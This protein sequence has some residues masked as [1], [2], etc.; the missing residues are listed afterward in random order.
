MA[1]E[2]RRP[3]PQHS[4]APVPV[5]WPAALDPVLAGA[6]I[7]LPRS[8]DSG[9]GVGL[10]TLLGSLFAF[11]HYLQSSD[12]SDNGQRKSGRAVGSNTD[13]FTTS[14]GVSRRRHTG[15]FGDLYD[16]SSL[17]APIGRHGHRPRCCWR[18]SSTMAWATWMSLAASARRWSIALRACCMLASCSAALL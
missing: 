17:P 1:R 8:A 5:A 6:S 12:H 11:C 15:L 4:S 7:F 9:A 3:S 13:R 18:A 2:Q 16:P 10:P 14:R